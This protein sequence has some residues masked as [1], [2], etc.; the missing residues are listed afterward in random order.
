ML[1]NRFNNNEHDTRDSLLSIPEKEILPLNEEK[2]N[3]KII[4]KII[5]EKVE[6]K[7]V[8]SDLEECISKFK[9]NYS[10][11]IMEN[12]FLN[13]FPED[14]RE[15]IIR[16]LTKFI[17]QTSLNIN[18]LN[19]NLGDNLEYL[20]RNNMTICFN[21]KWFLLLMKDCS[22]KNRYIIMRHYYRNEEKG[23]LHDGPKTNNF[24]LLQ[25]F[26]SE[27]LPTL[28]LLLDNKT[29]IRQNNF[30][31]TIYNP[32]NTYIN[33]SIKDDVLKCLV[34]KPLLGESIEK[35]IEDA[36]KKNGTKKFKIFGYTVSFSK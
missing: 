36:L 31:T 19:D 34:P 21:V 32:V 24:A 8:E 25:S 17:M 20:S 28:Y 9:L 30:P 12:S 26:G 15:L 16:E 10:N 7:I 18:D 11:S 35:M 4:E 3:E 2:V 27:S 22:F 14:D 6:G 33:D 29:L 23:P 13:A 1:R 5:E